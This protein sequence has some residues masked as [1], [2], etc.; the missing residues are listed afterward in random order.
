MKFLPLCIMLIA[1]I[2]IPNQGVILKNNHQQLVSN[3][4]ICNDILKSWW[5]GREAY[6]NAVNNNNDLGSQGTYC[7]QFS[8]NA[9][10]CEDPK[11]RN[12]SQ[13]ACVIEAAGSQKCVGNPC[14]QYNSGN[15]TLQATGGLCVWYTQDDINTINKNASKDKQIN[16]GHGCYRNP[17]NGPGNLNDGN[18]EQNCYNTTL[19]GN[20]LYSCTYCKGNEM[21]CQIA[22][23]LNT[24]ATCAQ[25]N[26]NG[27]G[28]SKSS[29]WEHHGN[30]NCQCSVG[31]AFCYANVQ[32]YKQNDTTGYLETSPWINT[33]NNWTQRYPN[34]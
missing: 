33:Y 21:G 14:N 2:I 18:A 29:I 6:V 30:T 23:A 26:R 16:T 19:R 31:S 12:N 34:N 17:C 10:L 1:S 5:K 32:Y 8:G 3:E 22:N 24:T 9:T 20:A 25:V 27:N 13:I 28:V 4:P 7:A 15:C 11:A